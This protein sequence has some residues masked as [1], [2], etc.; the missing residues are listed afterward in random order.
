MNS[1]P[2]HAVAK[3]RGQREF[4][5]AQ[6]TIVSSRVVKKSAAPPAALGS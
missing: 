1:M 5:R 4:A 6:A 3:G 2:Q